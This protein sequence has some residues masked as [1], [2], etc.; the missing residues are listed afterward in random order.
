MS[1]LLGTG[2]AFFIA[3]SQCLVNMLISE[4]MDRFMLSGDKLDEIQLS[5]SALKSRFVAIETVAW[6]AS[7]FA[8]ELCFQVSHVMCSILSRNGEGHNVQPLPGVDKGISDE[9]ADVLF[10]IMNTANFLNLN[11]SEVVTEDILERSA[12]IFACRDINVLVMNL[13]IQSGTLWDALFRSDG[14]KHK[15]LASDDNIR[16]IRE[17]LGGTLAALMVVSKAVSIDIEEAFNTMH[18]DAS[19]FLD[20]YKDKHQINNL[21]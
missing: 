17:A 12:S 16:Y 21:I 11:I 15:V 9:V 6:T 14:Y 18:K 8:A 5:S 4:I 7:S 3:D 1:P 20:K 2:A 19:L 13:A 10:N